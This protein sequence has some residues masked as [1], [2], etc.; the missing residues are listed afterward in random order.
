MEGLG[1]SIIH[2]EERSIIFSNIPFTTLKFILKNK[3]KICFLIKNF[4]YYIK[5]NLNFII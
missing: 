5:L 1:E 3:N 4:L 2:L